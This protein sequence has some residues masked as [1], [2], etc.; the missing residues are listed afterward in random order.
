[1]LWT[2]ARDKRRKETNHRAVPSCFLGNIRVLLKG[3]LDWKMDWKTKQ[4]MYWLKTRCWEYFF[5]ACIMLG[6]FNIANWTQN[7]IKVYVDFSSTS[8]TIIFHFELVTRH[9]W[10]FPE[11]T[12]TDRKCIVR[13][14]KKFIKL[15]WVWY[16]FFQFCFPFCFLFCFPVLL[17]IPKIVCLLHWLSF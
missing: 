14:K 1:M 8:V 10:T 2:P 11:K 15:I 6:K 17:V 13:R 7:Y 5:N 3:G 4:K 16:N 12:E 9:W